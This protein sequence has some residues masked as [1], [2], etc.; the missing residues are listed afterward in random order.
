M[1]QLTNPISIN[2][3]K[4]IKLSVRGALLAML[5]FLLALIVPM[6][7]EPSN[8]SVD[9][10]KEINPIGIIF[11]GG[12]RL[13]SDTEAPK[14][15][16]EI[17]SLNVPIL[18]IGY[19]MEYIANAFGGSVLKLESA[20]KDVSNVKLCDKSDLFKGLASEEAMFFN[21]TNFVKVVPEG[22]V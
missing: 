16:N 10:I 1:N 14:C 8:I 11:T 6:F 15:D 13:V 7:V 9:K 12:F 3:Y 18:G 2:L 5:L 21:Q 20:Y 17:F 4:L 19:G 22:F